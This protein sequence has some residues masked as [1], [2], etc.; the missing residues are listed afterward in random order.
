V[1]YLV[2]LH[3]DLGGRIQANKAEVVK[4]AADMRH[5]EAVR[6]MFNPDFSVAAIAPYGRPKDLSTISGKH[7]RVQ[8]SDPKS[9]LLNASDPRFTLQP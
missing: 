2:R 9:P 3:A 8:S 4:L 6:K 5:V 7:P 1:D